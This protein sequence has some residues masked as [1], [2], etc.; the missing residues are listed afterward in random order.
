[1][2]TEYAQQEFIVDFDEQYN[3]VEI[4]FT[5]VNSIALGELQTQVDQLVLDLT[6][7]LSLTN[8]TVAALNSEVSGLSTLI[9]AVS[10]DLTTEA[11]Q[12]IADILALNTTVLANHATVIG[13]IQDEA[14]ARAAGLL[15]EAQARG[16]AIQDATGTLVTD[17]AAL[18]IT[19]QGIA[20][21]LGAAEANIITV[22]TALSTE[23]MARAS[24]ISA[25]QATVNN[26]NAAV[27]SESLARSDGDNVLASQIEAL[28]ATSGTNV[29]L[30]PDE[31]TVG[32][33]A[34]DIWYDTDDGNKPYRYTGTAWLDVTDV[35][36][37]NNAAAIVSEQQARID[38]DNVNASSITSLSSTVDTKIV[39]FAQPDQPTPTAIGDIWLDT[40]AVPAN[41]MY[42]WNGTIWAPMR[43][44]GIVANA[45][46]LSTL[47][48]RVDTAEDQISTTSSALTIL[49]GRV[50]DAEGVNAAQ[51]TAING[52]DVRLIEAEGELTSQSNSITALQSTVNL[53]NRTFAQ[54]APPVASN[55]GDLWID[56]DSVPANQLYR[57]V[58]SP[59]NAWV[60]IRDAGIEANATAVS[61]L[62]TR[63]TAAEGTV[64]TLSSSVTTLSGRVDTVETENA[65]NGSAISALDVRLDSAEGTLTSQSGSITSLQSTVNQRNRTF[66]QA[67]A[68]TA[69]NTGDIWIDT[70]SNPAN[71]MYRWVGSPTNAWVAIRDAG[72]AGNA[73]A[74]SNLT[75]RVTNAEGTITSHS[76]TLTTLNS[77]VTT[78]QGD[79]N[80]AEL[81]IS[82]HTTAISNLNSDVATVES[83]YG[84]KVNANGHVAG[85]G[86]IAT[87]NSYGVGDT[88]FIV[89]AGS[90]K[91]FNGASAVAPFYVTGGAVY[92]QEAHIGSLTIDKLTSGTLSALVTQNGNWIVGTGK[93][94][95]DNGTY[96]KVSG[97]GFGS[98]NQFL[99]WFGPR[100]AN[101]N[102]ALCTEANAIQYL[103]TNGDAYFGGSLSAGTL[104]NAVTSTVIGSSAEA[105]LGPFGTN[106]GSKTVV[107][108]FTLS[109]V[110]TWYVTA[111][112]FTPDYTQSATLVLERSLNGGGTWTQVAGPHTV[113]AT[114]TYEACPLAGEQGRYSVTASGSFTYTDTST[115]TADFMYRLRITS[116]GMVIRSGYTV[117]TSQKLTIVST[118]E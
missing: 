9:T 94:I 19:V 74:I 48:T 98:S 14:N 15:A 95:F 100:P 104:R 69:S 20:S 110:Q 43:D 52:L 105:V 37:V 35:R 87:S 25:I 111:G 53:R 57:W 36:I 61:G 23:S 27:L 8:S 68:P 12:R 101:G 99:E 21:S 11:N 30:Q 90:F 29:F 41:Q 88:Q 49:T 107:H 31:P 89:D 50:T 113:T 3:L 75:T 84:V 55:P 109:H 114:V 96:M 85:F 118:E 60:A 93:I 56:T 39:T 10:G 34:G 77:S 91:V 5:G 71:Q 81:E 66:A 42:R 108:S 116:W 80:Q 7:D 44:G 76:G 28:S 16:A 82:G 79:L 112:N 97:V 103:K 115:S 32:M 78:L 4:R 33:L 83:R 59:T 40:D 13:A 63:V 106:G 2:T 26:T 67:S 1:M 102:V 38:G 54:A 64:S 18:A 24:E 58:G 6:N 47:D 46:A 70:D 45:T 117:N 51:G 17:Q 62:N 86:L 73:T 92:M 65:A 72:I 22:Q